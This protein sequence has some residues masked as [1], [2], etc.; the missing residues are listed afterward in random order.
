[1]T[2]RGRIKL[3][4]VS[5]R[6][7]LAPFIEAVERLNNSLDTPRVEAHIYYQH[8]L[9]RD[10][11]LVREACQ[12][13]RSADIV[14]LDWRSGIARSLP[15]IVSCISES[16]AKLIV[17][18]V[19]GD[20]RVLKVARI[21]VLRGFE[22]KVEAN[23]DRLDLTRM[24]RFFSW[25]ERSRLAG[26]APGL[27]D[28]K[29]W[30]LAVRYWSEGDSWNIEQMLRMLIS[31]LGYRVAY[32][33]PRRIVVPGTIYMPGGGFLEPG[34]AARVVG[35]PRVALLLYA[36]MHFDQTRVVAEALSEALRKRG[37]NTYMIV[38]GGN[39]D[40]VGQTETLEKALEGVRVEALVNLQWF[41]IEGGPYGGDY[42]KT[43]RLLRR[44]DV[45]LVNGLIMYMSEVSVWKRRSQGLS[46]IEVL[47]GVALPEADG[48]IEPIPL[49]GLDESR[50]KNVVP[51][52][53]RVERRAERLAAWVR[54]R[55]RKPSE[56]RVAIII[57]NYPPGRDN[58]GSASYLDVFASLE[59]ILSALKSEGYN[60]EALSAGQLREL[61][62][63]RGLFN[64]GRR[65]P[66]GCSI[67]VD[68][69]TYAKWFGELPACLQHRVLEV[70]GPPPGE[71]MVGGKGICIPGVVLGNVF[72]GV[73]P[74]RGVHESPDKLYHD[75]DLPPHHQYIAFYLWLQREF[76]ADVVVHL[77]THGTLELLP[78]KEVGL[79]E[80]SYPD[81]LIGS[82][83]HIYIWHVTNS[84]EM[85]A[86]KRRAYAYIVTHL[87]PP[88]SEAGLSPDLE[89]LKGLYDEYLEARQLHPE[90]AQ[91][92]ARRIVEEAEKLGFKV[93]SVD[94][95]HEILEDAEREAIPLGLHVLGRRWSREEAL[96]YLVLY[97][98]RKPSG[99][100]RIIAR[101]LGYSYEELL[102]NPK[103]RKVLERVDRLAEKFIELVAEGKLGEAL[104]L[105]PRKARAEAKRE[106]ETVRDALE[107]LERVD[108]LGSL[109]H[110]L[111]GGYVE[112]RVAGDPLRY[113]DVLPT[114]SNGYSFD[115][116]LVP[117]EAAVELGWKLAEE[118]LRRHVEKHGRWP[119][120]VGLVLWG[121]ETAGTRGET[122]GLIL[123]LLG[124]RLKRKGPWGYE[125]EPIPLEE[126]GRPRIDVAISICGFFRDMFPHLIAM[127][128]RAVRLVANLD[129]PPEMNYVRKH[130]LKLKAMKHLDPYA[131]IFGPKPGAYN[132]RLTEAVETGR[133][134]SGEELAKMYLEDMGYIYTER[135]HGVKDEEHVRNLLAT[136]EMAA[137]V[138]YS[139]EYDVVDLDHY[140]EFLGG[141]KL[142]AEK[143]RGGSIDTY[144]LDTSSHRTRISSIDRAIAYSSQTRILN[145]K[146]IEAMLSHDYD[147]VREV[148]ER[149]TNLLGLAATT[150]SI[151]EHIWH[152]I[153]E[154][155]LANRGRLERMLKA[156][157]HAVKRIA[158]KLQEAALRGY[159]HPTPEEK[160]TITA[161]LE[162]ITEESQ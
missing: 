41:R 84:S 8:E 130:T 115:P 141:L 2:G 146:W 129:E 72:I 52:W 118:L 124:V 10:P 9:E 73:Q 161:I 35:E 49:A 153:Y 93:G 11:E 80:C 57:Y 38:G 96:R 79:D 47:T 133:W 76:K 26:V 58:I 20:P 138:R 50:A 110:A 29:L 83:P 23:G 78:G 86:A 135:L 98:R 148:A 151:A 136:V 119:E 31:K 36:G 53:E 81:A 95:I 113:H 46:P 54:L 128:D 104:S 159:W 149:V 132:T 17:P 42:S 70:W 3:L 22:P 106:A 27:R 75:K 63:G 107:R 142:A 85:S 91:L 158:E 74:S 43:I 160:K 62:V 109:L 7:H 97:E 87:P 99:L 111:S 123:A 67:Y 102:E 92:L 37:I 140:Y 59:R 152:R 94:E 82:L 40:L 45:P 90:R 65:P 120:T 154:E 44:L 112:P 18:L 19:A 13:A 60:V 25:L 150:G 155:Y 127:I 6:T 66:A 16:S 147:G 121:F 64:A 156:N 89:R 131:R 162:D 12:A 4:L 157:P 145:P 101:A 108:E 55:S 137:Q 56:R 24:W 122:V 105:L 21:G 134:R 68:A 51:I 33:K 34:K 28:A 5:T 139:T 103:L 144:W 125:L 71:I 15:Q 1:M 77:G 88:P 69:E 32:E 114:G 117:S 39:E 61:F 48:A 30:A 143:A 100:H 14:L 116:R 126:L